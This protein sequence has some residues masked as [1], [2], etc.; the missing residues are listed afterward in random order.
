MAILPVFLTH[1]AN[2]NEESPGE[3]KAHARRTPQHLVIAGS[4]WNPETF[5]PA[6]SAAKFE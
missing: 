4:T 1:P 2:R 6:R 3:A 5:S